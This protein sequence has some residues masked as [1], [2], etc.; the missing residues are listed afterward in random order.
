MKIITADQRLA[1]RKRI[2]GAIFGPHGIGKTSLLWSLDPD[3]TLFLDLEGTWLS[4]IVRW[5]RSKSIRGK[6]RSIW[7]AL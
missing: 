4:R 1:E 5:I 2:K 6:K 7:L 3:K